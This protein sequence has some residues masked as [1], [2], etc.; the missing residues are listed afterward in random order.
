MVVSMP[1]RPLV[2]P[3]S[4]ITVS[5]PIMKMR[6]DLLTFIHWPVPVGEMQRLL[7]E[8]LKAS[9]FDGTAWVGLVP[10]L[11]DVSF[12]GVGSVPGVSVFPETNVRTYVEAPDGTQG[13]WFFSLDADRASACA[14]AR[15]GYRLP[16]MWASMNVAK[17]ADIV[18]YDCVRRVPGPVGAKNETAVRI[19][20]PYADEE[21]SDLEHW[22][23]G[24]WRLYSVMG[25]RLWGA[26]ADH[27]RWPLHRAELLTLDDDLVAASGLSAPTGTPMVHYS[28]GVE[29]RVSVPRP[30]GPR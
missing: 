7:P 16:Y 1:S 4:P 20:E 30:V 5:R 21:L 15:I 25:G 29:V 9:T 11:M 24:R 10:F 12:P 27:P 2:E 17:A 13:I 23:T 22:L 19:G 3:D 6:W 26:K 8:G 14:A 28:P 18:T